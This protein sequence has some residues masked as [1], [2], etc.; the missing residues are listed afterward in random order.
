FREAHGQLADDVG[1]AALSRTH[2]APR[3]RGAPAAAAEQAGEDVVDVEVA[4]ELDAAGRRARAA[5]GARERIGIEA[6]RH[7]VGPDGSV[8][9][10]V[11]FLALLRVA[12][13]RVR[14]VD[15][16]EAL[17]LLLVVAGDV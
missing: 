6:L 16:L 14:F 7:A 5:E 13:H 3:L 8:L 9:E 12:Q 4:A 15:L 2:T 17:G 10:A 11:V 1:A